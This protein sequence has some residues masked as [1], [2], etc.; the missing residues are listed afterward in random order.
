MLH[1][2]S[3]HF[4]DSLKYTTPGG[5]TVYGGGGIMPDIF[6]ALDTV[7]ASEYLSIVSYRGIINQFGFDFADSH[8]Q[9]LE[10]YGSYRNY[11]ERFV[12]TDQMFRDFVAYA[13]ARGVEPNDHD[14][15]ESEEVLK[16]R[17][18]AYIARNIW[19]NDGYYAVIADDDNVLKRAR[20][21]LTSTA[22]L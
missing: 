16:I 6:V 15:A 7:G 22:S 3:I 5:R 10:S 8:R 1:Q 9:K 12:F 21:A 17:I 18:K 13:R 2:D 20:M 19:G 4:P 11:K 14:L